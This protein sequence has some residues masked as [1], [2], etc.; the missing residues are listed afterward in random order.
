VRIP[1][2]ANCRFI[3]VEHVNMSNPKKPTSQS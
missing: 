1:T 3:K 2:M